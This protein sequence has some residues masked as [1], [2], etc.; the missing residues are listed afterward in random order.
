MMRNFVNAVK[1]L[2]AWAALAICVAYAQS[3]KI[4]AKVP[5]DFVVANRNMEPGEYTFTIDLVQS[6]VLV[7]GAA[8]GSAAF[9]LSYK[10]QTGTMHQDSKLVFNRYGDR[11]FLSQVWPS[12]VADGRALVQSTKER[13]LAKNPR[14]PE[15]VALIVKTG[16]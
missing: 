11:Y 4:V 3:S 5:F 6:T 7:R 10:A 9:A 14:K 1:T 8:D 15:I 12:G 16:R 2:A 13:E